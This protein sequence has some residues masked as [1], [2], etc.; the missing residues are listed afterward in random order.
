MFERLSPAFDP[1]HM[2]SHEA[3][4]LATTNVKVLARRE[5]QASCDMVKIPPA[6]RLGDL[7]ESAYQCPLV[8]LAEYLSLQSSFYYVCSPEHT[9]R[10]RATSKP[11]RG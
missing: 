11:K 8:D 3:G 2:E 6:S 5:E 10:T 9:Q 1:E 4:T 7:V